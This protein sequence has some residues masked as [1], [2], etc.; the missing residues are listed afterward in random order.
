M[1]RPIPNRLSQNANGI[2]IPAQ[3]LVSGAEAEPRLDVHSRFSNGLLECSNSVHV[4][5]AL[6]VEPPERRVR[7][8]ILRPDRYRVPQCF[9]SAS[10]VPGTSLGSGQLSVIE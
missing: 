6:D 3:C 4:V 1:R 2:V 9:F 8:P 5:G 10:Q 7:R